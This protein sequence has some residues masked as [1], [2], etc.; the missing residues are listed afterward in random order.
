MQFNVTY[1]QHQQ[2]SAVAEEGEV[3]AALQNYIEQC[4]GDP[5][6]ARASEAV[7]DLDAGRKPADLDVIATALCEWGFSA[8]P[9]AVP[10]KTDEASDYTA[11]VQ[12]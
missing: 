8:P 4:P 9:G 5:E 1:W 6:A 2:F 3:R 7:A 10:D 12:P 11:E